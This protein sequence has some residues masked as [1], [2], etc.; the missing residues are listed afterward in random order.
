MIALAS[1]T[2]PQGIVIPI[3]HAGDS[4]RYGPVSQPNFTD[5]P[6]RSGIIAAP[7]KLTLYRDNS[8]NHVSV[9][10]N[11]NGLSPAVFN[12]LQSLRSAPNSRGT[13]CT[14]VV[15]SN[16]DAKT[17]EKNLEESLSE[18]MDSVTS[19]KQSGDVRIK[20]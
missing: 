20:F 11:G 18:M 14:R 17:F 16:V 13:E 7:E 1:S 6:I 9:L 5:Q 15:N 2:G 4:L 12:D 10:S 19:S 8:T 3:R